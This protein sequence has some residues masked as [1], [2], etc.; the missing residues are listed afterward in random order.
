MT[1]QGPHFTMFGAEIRP[2]SLPKIVYIFPLFLRK[3]PPTP[4]E[5]QNKQAKLKVFCLKQEIFTI[6]Y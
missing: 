4:K 1:F 3:I 2:H 6:S 5:K